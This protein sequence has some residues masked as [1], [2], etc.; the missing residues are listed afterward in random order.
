MAGFLEPR[1]E[2]V[3]ELRVEVGAELHVGRGDDEVL[4]FTPIT[5]GTVTGPRLTGRVLAGAATGGSPAETSRS[6]MRAT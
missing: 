2:F 3:F 1:L 4:G 6:S 5:G